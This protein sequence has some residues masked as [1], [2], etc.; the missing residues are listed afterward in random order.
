MMRSVPLGGGPGGVLE[1]AVLDVRDEEDGPLVEADGLVQATR[2]L[3]VHAFQ[4]QLPGLVV[5]ASYE[6]KDRIFEDP[7]LN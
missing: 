7:D 4:E 5:D 2:L 1:G 6:K 3:Q